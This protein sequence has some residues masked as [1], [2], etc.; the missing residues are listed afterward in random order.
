MFYLPH[1]ADPRNKSL[2][3]L[4]L[5]E[6]QRTVE[7]WKSEASAKYRRPMDLSGKPPAELP[8][9][10]FDTKALYRDEGKTAPVVK[11]DP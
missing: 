11:P 9:A 6:H 5:D 2:L 1:M 8:P 10:R 4:D 3:N 7:W